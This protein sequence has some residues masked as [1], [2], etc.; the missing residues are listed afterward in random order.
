MKKLILIL[1]SFCV[2]IG[3]KEPVWNAPPKDGI[4]PEAIKSYRV[5][6]LN[7]KSIIYF[8]IQ[9]QNTLYVEAQY[10]LNNGAIKN[11][12]A[13]KFTDSL[14]VEGFANAQ[15]YEVELFAVGNNEQKSPPLKITINPLKPT[16]QLAFESLTSSATF[17]G[18]TVQATN[19]Q[20][21]PIVIETMRKES[22]GTWTSIDKYYTS[23]DVIKYN[24]R[25]MND[26]LQNFGFFIRDRWLNY[27]DT[28]SNSL[29]PLRE[30]QIPPSSIGVISASVL[31]GSAP[32]HNN[33]S[34]YAATKAVDGIIGLTVNANYYLTARG[35]GMPQHFNLDLK[36]P[37]SL[38]RLVY[39]QRPTYFYR[40]ISPR[41]VAVWGSNN[42]ATD[43]SFEGWEKLGEF[44]AI[45]PSGLPMDTNSAEDD[46]VAAAGI[47]F[48]FDSATIPVRYLRIQTLETWSMSDYLT[49]TEYSIF[50]NTVN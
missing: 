40:G 7:G 19:P 25:G 17:G 44:E 20:R 38:S 32:S 48:E 28:I 13:S 1:F 8:D 33:S 27:S 31:P 24:I 39:Y 16:Y 36:V 5:H 23:T 41:K 2:L 49:L 43:G 34:T 3:C 6:N 10:A 26:S 9:D 12:K 42:P 22:D 46:A 30:I 4:T 37:Y 50:G 45:K 29:K 18:I 14:V 47:N 35:S 11:V 15:Q 21:E